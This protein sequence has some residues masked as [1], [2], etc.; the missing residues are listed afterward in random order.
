MSI[1][2]EP[3]TLHFMYRDNNGSLEDLFI[4]TGPLSKSAAKQVGKEYA[5]QNNMRLFQ[6]FPS[7]KA[8]HS[9]I[10]VDAKCLP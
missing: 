7:S 6:V 2:R 8:N 10:L 1:N 3:Y 9:L 4:E 5:K